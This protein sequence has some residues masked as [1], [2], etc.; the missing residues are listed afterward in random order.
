MD[1]P[2]WPENI[3]EEENR[4]KLA[5]AEKEYQR[6]LSRLISF[7]RDGTQWSGTGSRLNVLEES[8]GENFRRQLSEGIELNAGGHGTV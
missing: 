3:I 4:N 7:K 8:L 1:F 2:K 6:Q 5:K